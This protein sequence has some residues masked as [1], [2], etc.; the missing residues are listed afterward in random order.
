MGEWLGTPATCSLTVSLIGSLITLT[1]LEALGSLEGTGLGAL[2]SKPYP[3]RG[4]LGGMEEGGTEGGGTAAV[5]GRLETGAVSSDTWL[6]ESGF[7]SATAGNSTPLEPM[8]GRLK[9]D[10]NIH[11]V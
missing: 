8:A 2:L 10:N 3:S 11:F 6:W 9:A 4:A 1:L 7:C 5:G